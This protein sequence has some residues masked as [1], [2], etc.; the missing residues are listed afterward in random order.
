MWRTAVRGSILII[1]LL[2]TGA[3]LAAC[4]S[5][6]APTETQPASPA[7]TAAFTTG[8]SV[9]AT[10]TDGN[11]YLATET[12]VTGADVTVTYTDDG[13]SATL[14][15]SDVRAIPASAF[16]A[17]DRVLAVWSKGRFYPGEV[18]RVDG[19]SYTVKWDDGSA[20]SVIEAGKI[21]AE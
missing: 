19:A 20:P 13:T 21:I 18:T 14:S 16:A 10:W 6:S 12:G 8:Q 9:A 3:G 17:G 2:A 11:L 15:A 1:A 7:A 5:S 4:G